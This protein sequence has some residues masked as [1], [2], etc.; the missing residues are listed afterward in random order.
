MDGSGAETE[1]ELG[2]VEEESCKQD[3]PGEWA[4]YP[5]LRRI[6][7]GEDTGDG[8]AGGGGEGVSG[9]MGGGGGVGV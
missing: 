6:T 4:R 9:G 2:K 1:V 7:T 3:Y 5:G 8:G